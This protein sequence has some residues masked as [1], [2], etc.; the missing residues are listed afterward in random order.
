MNN[1]IYYWKT[2]SVFKETEDAMTIIFETM[3]ESF[4]YMPGQFINVRQIVNG[5]TVSRSYSLSSSPGEDENPAITI[6]KVEGGRMSNYILQDGQNI[7]LWEVDGP[8]GSF[9]ADLSSI[10]KKPIVLIGGGSGITPLY[11]IL[12]SFLRHS[13]ADV[14]LIDCNRTWDDAI[15]A[16]QITSL[17]TGI[18]WQATG[19]SFFIGRSGK[20]KLSM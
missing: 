13:D 19:A 1:K 17:E 14:V 11:S 6:K 3:G 18:C 8:H 7:K 10:N 16:N 4:K 2:A 5:E 9:Y 20:E 15:F 12:K